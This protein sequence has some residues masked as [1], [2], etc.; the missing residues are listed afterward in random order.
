MY[1]Y[2]YSISMIS[3]SNMNR[4][5]F[6]LN[7]HQYVAVHPAVSVKATQA[8]PRAQQQSPS[9]SPKPWIQQCHHR[10]WGFFFI[11]RFPESWG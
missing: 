10:K 1:V 4:Q 11:W 9:D 3:D 7:K 2:I 6:G 5:D 8:A